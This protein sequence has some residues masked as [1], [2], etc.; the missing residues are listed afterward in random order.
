MVRA[1]NRI[2]TKEERT[3]VLTSSEVQAAV[4]NWIVQAFHLPAQ[5]EDNETWRCEFIRDC[6]Y[7]SYNAVVT[8]ITERKVDGVPYKEFSAEETKDASSR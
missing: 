2:T 8:R 3:Y 7:D 1:T 5:S 4:I 6:V